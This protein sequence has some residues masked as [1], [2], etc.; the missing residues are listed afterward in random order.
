[1]IVMSY[2]QKSERKMSNKQNP[3][4]IRPG[5][6]VSIHFDFHSSRGEFTAEVTEIHDRI[7]MGM[8][9]AISYI[10]DESGRDLEAERFGIPYGC[11]VSH[12][13]KVV[14]R[15]PYV[16]KKGARP[17]NIFREGQERLSRDGWPGCYKFGGI[18]ICYSSM[19]KLVTLVLAHAQG[20]LDRPLDIDKF[21]ALWEKSK[22]PGKVEIPASFS[23]DRMTDLY[24]AVR[25]KIFKK[26]VLANKEKILATRKEIVEDGIRFHEAMWQ[27]DDEDNRDYEEISDYA[28][29]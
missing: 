7:D 27:D 16:V 20:T 4:G 2:I 15:A 9:C 24:T 29:A 18:K 6:V 21:R 5:D 23:E 1:M 11:S 14:R 13:K 12:V 19:E 17:K 3:L 25:W 10:P 28:D 26:F 8:D 22:F